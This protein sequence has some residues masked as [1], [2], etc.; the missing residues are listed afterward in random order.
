VTAA[1]KATDW[2]T[3]AGF[4]VAVSVVVELLAPSVTVSVARP[5]SCP[6]Q[7]SV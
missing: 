5:D 4:G 3:V 2:P 1:F 7:V 6:P